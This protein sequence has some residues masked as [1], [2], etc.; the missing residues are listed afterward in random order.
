M[1]SN[2]EHISGLKNCVDI[3]TPWAMERN[4]TRGDICS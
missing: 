3:G 1:R 4:E 2:F